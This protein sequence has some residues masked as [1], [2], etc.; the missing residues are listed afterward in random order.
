MSRFKDFANFD[1]VK[2]NDIRDL[3]ADF[4]VTVDLYRRSIPEGNIGIDT[5]LGDLALVKRFNAIFSRD[6]NHF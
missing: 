3:L 1:E 5:E 6:R 2:H 4:G